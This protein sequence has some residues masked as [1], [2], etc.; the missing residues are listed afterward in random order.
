M[1]SAARILFL[2]CLVLSMTAGCRCARAGKMEVRVGGCNT[3][4]RDFGL[5]PIANERAQEAVAELL[6]P[7]MGPKSG[8][9][10]R[11]LVVDTPCFLQIGAVD[12]QANE[13]WRNLAEQITALT[14]AGG[15]H[16]AERSLLRHTTGPCFPPYH[17]DF[18][19]VGSAEAVARFRADLTEQ[20][21]KGFIPA[22]TRG[23]RSLFISAGVNLSMMEP[24]GDLQVA[25]D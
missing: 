21:W 4:E 9:A 10:C 3:T 12:S 20:K 13:V 5:P 18:R 22:S 17:V 24:C 7:G 14:K 11:A 16:L 19:A 8:P 23:E 6:A 15:L 25:I 1:R 2:G